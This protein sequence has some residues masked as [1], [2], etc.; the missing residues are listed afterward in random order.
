MRQRWEALSG[1]VRGAVFILIASIGFPAM[2][3]LSRIL[4]ERLHSFEISLARAFFGFVFI[5][6]LF[7]REGPALLATRMPGRHILRACLGTMGMMTAFYAFNNLPLADAIALSFAKPLFMVIL[8]ALV[9]HESVHRRRWTATAIGFAGVIIMLRP[10]GGFIDPAALVAVSNALFAASVAILIKQLVAT[11]RK[12]TILAY[13]GIVSTIL[14]AIPTWFVWLTP[15]PH[16]I[17]LMAMMA[18]IGSLS[19]IALM[20]GFKLGEAS[21]LAPFDYARLPVAAIYGAVLFSEW[22]DI[23]TFLGAAVIVVSTFYLARLEHRRS[24]G[25]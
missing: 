16:E 21:A 24:S 14:T 3:V 1:N 13:L 25:P 19:Q 11:E 9:L 5:L 2:A 7:W 12:A 22:P 10:Q 18:G 8:A 20:H 4:G 23:H 6:P 15:T 17:V